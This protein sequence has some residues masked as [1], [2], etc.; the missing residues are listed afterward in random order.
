M[1]NIISTYFL[2]NPHVGSKGAPALERDH[3]RDHQT[4]H[5]QTEIGGLTIY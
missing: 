1:V 5:L 2:T 4:K 3:Q